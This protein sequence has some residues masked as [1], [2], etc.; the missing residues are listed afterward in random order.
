MVFGWL[1]LKIEEGVEELNGLEGEWLSDN[2]QLCKEV[3]ENK[4]IAY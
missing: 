1:D 3:V 4:N 2:S